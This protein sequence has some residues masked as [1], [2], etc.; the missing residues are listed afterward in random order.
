MADEVRCAG[1]PFRERGEGG[2][3]HCGHPAAGL[4]RNRR[5]RRLSGLRQTGIYNAPAWCPKRVCATCGGTG[6]IRQ[7]ACVTR[8][9]APVPGSEHE[10]VVDCPGCA[11]G[12][13]LEGKR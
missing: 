1:C 7:A 10:I 2:W 3:H 5:E 8:N 4:K 13:G 12:V 11:G 9:G 6:E